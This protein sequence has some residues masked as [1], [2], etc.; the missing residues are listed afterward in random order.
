M[1]DLG[2][3]PSQGQGGGSSDDQSKPSVGSSPNSPGQGLLAATR[4]RA[5]ATNAQHTSVQLQRQQASAERVG[6]AGQLQRARVDA[7][8]LRHLQRRHDDALQPSLVQHRVFGWRC[9]ANPVGAD[10]LLVC[11]DEGGGSR[12][13][14]EKKY[15]PKM[16]V[17]S[18]R[19]ISTDGVNPSGFSLIH[20]SSVF[21]VLVLVPTRGGGARPRQLAPGQGGEAEGRGAG[22]TG[23]GSGQE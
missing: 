4:T 21:I 8:L 10:P 19:Q 9:G 1:A 23:S 14:P 18:A 2:S 15:S 20:V 22:A 5:P 13:A 6:R 17:H 7:V 12:A 11:L 3:P 16:R